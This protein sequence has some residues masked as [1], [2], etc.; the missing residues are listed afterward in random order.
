MTAV[1]FLL[2]AL[3]AWRTWQL[4]AFD[5]ILEPLRDRVTITQD[6]AI[7][8][9]LVA[10]IGCRFCFGFWIALAWTLLYAAWPEG[11]FWIAL[12]LALSAALVLIDALMG[13]AT[14]PTN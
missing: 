14:A 13:K 4:L 6:G 2:L 7:R 12:P 5:E 10:F 8:T 3:A 9:G 11:S 1:T